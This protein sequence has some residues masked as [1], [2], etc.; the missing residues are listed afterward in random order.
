ML[1]FFFFFFFKFGA[2]ARYLISLF[3]LIR[4]GTA[5]SEISKPLH[6]AVPCHDPCIE[7][8]LG[9]ERTTE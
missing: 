7:P 8:R 6:G 3:F 5:R 4:V 9:F 1:L 2:E